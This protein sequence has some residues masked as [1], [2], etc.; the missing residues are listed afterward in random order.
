M[1]MLCIIYIDTYTCIK[2]NS[3][4]W[5]IWSCLVIYTWSSNW[6][7]NTICRVYGFI[8]RFPHLPA[9]KRDPTSEYHMVVWF[10]FDCRMCEVATDMVGAGM[11]SRIGTRGPDTSTTTLFYLETRRFLGSWAWQARIHAHDENK[12]VL[13]IFFGPTSMYRTLVFSGSIICKSKTI[14]RWSS[15]LAVSN[16]GGGP[17][18]PSC[19]DGQIGHEKCPC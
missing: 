2:L 17:R 19:W 9:G 6:K 7:W 15:E 11:F 1:Y 13:W 5:K 12:T 16:N 18:D 10:P 3:M 8:E 4:C 14:L